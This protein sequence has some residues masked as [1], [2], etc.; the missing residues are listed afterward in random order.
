MAL[1]KKSRKEEEITEA[2][3]DKYN[4]LGEICELNHTAPLSEDSCLY[5][6]YRSYLHSLLRAVHVA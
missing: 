5:S 6:R 3:L 1:A 2:Q 4:E